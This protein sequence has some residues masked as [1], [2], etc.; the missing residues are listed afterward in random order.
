M[1]KSYLCTLT[2]F[3]FIITISTD[4]NAKDTSIG[5]SY[6]EIVKN[7]G[8]MF[9]DLGRV[10]DKNKQKRY[11]GI[12]DDGYATIELIG[13]PEDISVIKLSLTYPEMFDKLRVDVISNTLITQGIWKS[14]FHRKEDI[15]K[16]AENTTRSLADGKSRTIHI[17]NLKII[18][19]PIGKF[20][21]MDI[22]IAHKQTNIKSKKGWF[23][24]LLE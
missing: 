1:I 5:V 12:S 21:I 18:L 10:L 14:I 19:D 2:L 8:F 16:A 11:M 17:N 23:S 7:I 24:R 6:S 22:T 13:N 3:L 4:L 20:A 15:D 9:R